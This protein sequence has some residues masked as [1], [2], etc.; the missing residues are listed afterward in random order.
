MINLLIA[1]DHEI[2][3]CGYRRLFEAS[4]KIKVIAEAAT[5]PQAFT[6]YKENR[7]DVLLMDIMM[8][9]PGIVA[10]IHRIISYNPSA[11]ILVVSMHA[12]LS[13]VERCFKAG[14][15][16]YVTKSSPAKVLLD[17]VAQVARGKRFISSDIAEEMA[18]NQLNTKQNSTL[19]VLT[20]REFE[21][22]LR[23][24]KGQSISDISNEMHISNKTI[25]N[26]ASKI[27][28]Q[29]SLSNTAEL[30]HLAL[31]E[32]LIENTYYL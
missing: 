15:L 3:R 1:D 23:L 20:S 31:Q 18:L 9:G 6:L 12:N 19:S 30:I 17:G 5:G 24:A 21:V 14:A 16:G 11:Y 25:S 8:P 10:S 7:P 28:K 4:G 13:F 32:T 2:V 27:K 26:Y 22:F 29:L